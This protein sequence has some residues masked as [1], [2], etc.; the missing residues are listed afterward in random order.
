MGDGFGTI[1]GDNAQGKRALSIVQYQSLASFLEILDVR[2]VGDILII[3]LQG[4]RPCLR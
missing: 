2:S 1:T 4:R 3:T